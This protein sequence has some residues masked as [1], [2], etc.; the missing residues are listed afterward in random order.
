MDVTR[1]DEEDFKERL[2]EMKTQT[3]GNSTYVEDILG[4]ILERLG[5]LEEARERTLE[6]LASRS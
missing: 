5:R 1:K 2:S 3:Q 4:R 6:G